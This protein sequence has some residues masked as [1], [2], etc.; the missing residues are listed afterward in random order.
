MSL[1]TEFWEAAIEMELGVKVYKGIK[2]MKEK[3]R[4][5]WAPDCQTTMQTLSMIMYQGDA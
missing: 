5:D 1:C 2:F 3:R 4:L